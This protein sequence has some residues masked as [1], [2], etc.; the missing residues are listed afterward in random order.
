MNRPDW[1]VLKVGGDAT[2]AIL[3]TESKDMFCITDKAGNHIEGNVGFKCVLTAI[4]GEIV[5]IQ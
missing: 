2:F 5:Y 4:K 3:D 1:G